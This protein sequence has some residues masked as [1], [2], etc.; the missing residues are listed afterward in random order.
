MFQAE[1]K[2]GGVFLGVHMSGAA[3]TFSKNIDINSLCLAHNCRVQHFAVDRW[4][5]EGDRIYLDD[6]DRKESTSL[7]VLEAPGHTPDSIAIYNHAEKLLFVGDNIYPYT[8]IHLDC[9]GSDVKSYVATLRKLQKFVD[10]VK[11]KSAAQLRERK[12]STI[13]CTPCVSEATAAGAGSG[14]AKAKEGAKGV[15]DDGKGDASAVSDST[16]TAAAAAAAATT[17]PAGDGKAKEASTTAP[18]QQSS[19]EN[20]ASAQAKAAVGNAGPAHAQD[21]V[22][23]GK[24]PSDQAQGRESKAE[25]PTRRPLDQ[26]LIDD[27]CQLT[28]VSYSASS[29]KFSFDAL[30]QVCNY[31]LNEMLNM[32][33]MGG[34]SSISQICPPGSGKPRPPPD[35]GA[36]GAASVSRAAPKP[37]KKK[38][39]NAPTEVKLCCGHVEAQLSTGAIS[40][41]LTLLECVGAGAVRPS[42]IDS[43]YG[44]YTN[45]TFSIMMS[46]KSK[47]S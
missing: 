31:S 1:K 29:S 32:F 20:T 19:P 42:H 7:E 13:P 17:R 10:K 38:V 25:R 3:T 9:L 39:F 15:G 44:E 22:A 11:G 8:V 45:G 43:G 34:V 33:F 37:E 6:K 16:P 26:K 18:P 14:A 40:Q 12:S 47:M 27:F 21:G 23:N 24:R 35:A 2:K 30:L 5:K 28:G 4:L 36:R 46:L 41:I